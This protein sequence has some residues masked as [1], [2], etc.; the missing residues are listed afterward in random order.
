MKT[1]WHIVLLLALL[2]LQS[3]AQK[4]TTEVQPDH[5]AFLPGEYLRFNI[6]YGP[7]DAGEAVFYV[8]DTLVKVGGKPHYKVAV[9]G[10]SYKT[11]DVFYKVRDYYYS[12]I[13]TASMQ[14]TVY[15]RNVAEGDYRDLESYRFNRRD[16]VA[17][18]KANGEKKQIGI[19]PDVQD[20][21]SMIYYARSLYFRDKKVGAYAPIN[22]F[23]ASQWFACG[24][25]YDGIEMVKTP[26]GTFRCMKIVPILVEG[27]I[28]KGQ[29]DMVV[30][31]T[32]DDNQLPIRI[33]S[34]IF[35]GSIKVDLMEYSNLKFPLKAKVK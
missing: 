26:I 25:R 35:V 20:L 23:F 15:S 12:Y 32:D 29:D 10:R 18:G 7:V 27:R 3:F 1:S 16:T 13:D 19:P 33:V 22:V 9:T 6:H 2:P 34:E 14:P 4:D 17:I 28:F 8:E 11:W 5:R 21:A 31:V 30:Y 24:M